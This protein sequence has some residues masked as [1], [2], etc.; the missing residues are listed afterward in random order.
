MLQRRQ[1]W[2]D[3]YTGTTKVLFKATAVH[4]AQVY[5]ARCFSDWQHHIKYALKWWWEHK[6]D[7]YENQV[8]QMNIPRG[9]K[10]NR[11]RDQRAQWANKRLRT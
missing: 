2:L 8:M 7:W 5:T 9:R 11:S 6:R 3:D 4:T 1:S 10:R